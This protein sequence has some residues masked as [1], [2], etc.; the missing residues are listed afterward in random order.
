MENITMGELDGKVAIVTGGSGGLGKCICNSLAKQGVTLAILYNNHY[1]DAK[2]L[3]DGE[4]LI[5]L[6]TKLGKLG[7]GPCLW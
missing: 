5:A 2:I 4:T 6:R 3:S 1:Q 7:L